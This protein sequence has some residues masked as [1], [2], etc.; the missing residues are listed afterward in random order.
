MS[1]PLNQP[2]W[3]GAEDLDP[4]APMTHD[5][6]E[7]LDA[8]AEDPERYNLWSYEDMAEA[9][10]HSQP[11]TG[12]VWNRDWSLS[13]GPVDEDHFVRCPF[14][15]TLVRRVRPG[16]GAFAALGAVAIAALVAASS[17]LLGRLGPALSWVGG[18]V[19][20]VIGVGTPLV[21][22]LM[23][24]MTVPEDCPS[25]GGPVR[26]AV[27]SEWGAPEVLESAYTAPRWTPKE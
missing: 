2:E 14:C 23:R 9:S 4:L 5:G 17:I 13:E 25:C 3:V 15:S 16:G 1:W 21:R 11:P 19:W 24:P 20:V 7:A 18:L 6:E 8:W 22:R 12:Q 27:L 10:R 26:M